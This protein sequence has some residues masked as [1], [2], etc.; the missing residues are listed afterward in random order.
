MQDGIAV[1]QGQRFPPVP[2]YVVGSIPGR[3]SLRPLALEVL[4][5]R[6]GATL[7]NAGTP[8]RDLPLDHAGCYRLEV[9]YRLG[10]PVL[11][12]VYLKI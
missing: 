8:K 12:S 4:I 5:G 3:V 11:V 9:G 6:A 2:L 1:D 7:N 10:L